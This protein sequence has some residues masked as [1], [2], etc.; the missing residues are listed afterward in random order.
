MTFIKHKGT[1]MDFENLTKMI[2]FAQK[3]DAELNKV[4]DQEVWDDE[5]YKR[6]ETVTAQYNKDCR[7]ILVAYW[8]DTQE[9]NSLNHILLAFGKVD[10]DRA[11]VFMGQAERFITDRL[12]GKFS[13]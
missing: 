3:I 2:P 10:K 11:F 12:N 6:F 7:K 1:V 13:G 4:L 8:K 9:I 5:A